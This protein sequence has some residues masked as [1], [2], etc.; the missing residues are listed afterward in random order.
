VNREA[1]SD[2]LERRKHAAHEL[3]DDRVDGIT[4]ELAQSDDSARMASVLREEIAYATQQRDALDDETREPWQVLI[5][6]DREAVEV[7][8][9]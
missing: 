7:V 9:R 2:C 8:S 6:I 4:R 1:L 3:G 5:E